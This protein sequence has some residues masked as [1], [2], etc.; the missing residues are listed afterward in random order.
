MRTL[1]TLVLSLFTMSVISAC[2]ASTPTQGAADSTAT[3]SPAPSSL[4]L[5]PTQVQ[6]PKTK[7]SQP[8]TDNTQLS[9]QTELPS[10]V[11]APKASPVK[12]HVSPQKGITMHQ[13]T[14]RF[15]NLEGGFWGIITDSGKSILPQGLAEEFKKDG[16]RLSFK[17]EAITDMMTI[18]QWGTFARVSDIEVIGQVDSQSAD[19][20]L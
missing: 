14:V 19:P 9:T 18:Q 6:T 2:N 4:P 7:T 16:L 17:A 12:P 20:R 5:D 3:A 10:Q 15:I 13:G 1:P 11:T 8:M